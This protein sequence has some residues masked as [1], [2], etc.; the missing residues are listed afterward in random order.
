MR[1]LI[2][3]GAGFIGSHLAQ[4]C[5][6]RGDEVYIID[7]LSTGS[8]DN[9]RFLQDN[10]AYENKLFVHINT[11]LNADIMLEL[12]GICDMVF[13]LAA[14]VGVQTILDKPLESIVT[15]IQGTEKVLEMC[16]KFKKRVLIAS[17]SEVYGKHMHAPLVETDN[18]IYGPS[19]KFRWSYAASKLMDEFT[20]LAYHRTNG[21]EVTIARLFN[22]VG[23]RQ[24]GAYGMVIPRFVTQALKNDPITVFGDGNQTRTFTFVKDVVTALIKLIESD[25]S[26]GEVFNVG[27]HEEISISDLAQKIIQMTGSSSTIKLIPYEEA[28]G[29]DFEDMLRR[30]PST[31]KLESITGFKPDKRL[32]FILSQVIAS[33]MGK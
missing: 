19:S 7:D 17:T 11:I 1:I 33:I 23:P 22:T 3:G 30:V 25:Q 27:G 4:T 14:A 15:N 8:M 29:K 16:N 21:L 13:H 9:I 2:T 10:P 31:D 6:E 18:I 5:L 28:F 20:A 32:D 24:T 12:T 26:V